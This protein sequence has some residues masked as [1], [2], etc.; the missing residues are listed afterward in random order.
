MDERR[1][2]ARNQIE[3]AVPLEFQQAATREWARGLGDVVFGF[4]RVLTAS[5]DTGFIAAA[6]AEIAFPTGKESIGLGN[7]YAIVEPFAMWGKILPKNAFIQMHGGF[8]VPF[9]SVAG[10]K[11]GFIRTAAGTTFFADR[12]FG[13]SWTPQVEVLWARPEGGA[14][15]WDIVP[16]LQV[17]LSKLQHVMVAAG[18]RVPLGE[19]EERHTQVLAYLLWDWFDGSFFDFWK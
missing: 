9:D 10:S 14:S 3:V 7:G 16:Q 1:F 13:R 2:G 4:R 5:M 15:E 17:S 8:E 18:V 12:G 11:E 6:G 19:R